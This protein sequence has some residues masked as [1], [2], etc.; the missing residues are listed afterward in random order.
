MPVRDSTAWRHAQ[1]QR[2]IIN[3]DSGVGR[4]IICSWDTCEKDGYEMY[5]V[6]V[7]MGNERGERTMNYVFCS[8]RHKYYWLQN[9]HPGSNN[10]L[11]SGRRN[12]L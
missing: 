9:T 12:M 6:V 7:H 3:H 8:D 10:N 11:P 5:K 1:I 4:K 2:K